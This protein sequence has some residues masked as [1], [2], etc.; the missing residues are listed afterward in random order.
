MKTKGQ[1]DEVRR[2]H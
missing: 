2:E 1:M